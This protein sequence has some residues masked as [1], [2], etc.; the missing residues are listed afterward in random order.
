MYTYST[1]IGLNAW[2]PFPPPSST[3]AVLDITPVSVIRKPGKNSPNL[4]YST[5]SPPD[6][7]KFNQMDARSAILYLKI[8]PKSI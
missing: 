7:P 8:D 5:E 1:H 2:H 3:T 4:G 6:Q